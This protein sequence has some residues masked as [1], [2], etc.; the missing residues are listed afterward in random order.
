[1]DLL[2]QPLTF[3]SLLLLEQSLYFLPHKL[4]G[5]SLSIIINLFPHHHNSVNPFLLQQH[6]KYLDGSHQIKG[7]SNVCLLFGTVRILVVAAIFGATVHR[8]SFQ[9]KPMHFCCSTLGCLTRK[10]GSLS[11]FNRGRNL[12]KS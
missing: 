9:T 10:L 7:A 11:H 8:F 6:F 1:M 4:H 2:P 5:A 3:T 12:L